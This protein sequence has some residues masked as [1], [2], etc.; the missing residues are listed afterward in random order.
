MRRLGPGES[1][2]TGRY[3]DETE[4]SMTHNTSRVSAMSGLGGLA[5]A[6]PISTRMKYHFFSFQVHGTTGYQGHS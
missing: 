3:A 2:R 1:V 4:G 6:R 5:S